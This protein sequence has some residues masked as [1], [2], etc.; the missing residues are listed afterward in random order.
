MR[1]VPGT[2]EGDTK[3]QEITARPHAGPQIH[4]WE[5]SRA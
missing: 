2:W 3:R 5:Y 4:W 1:K